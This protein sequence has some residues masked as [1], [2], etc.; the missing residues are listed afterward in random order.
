[1]TNMCMRVVN[2]TFFNYSCI[3]SKSNLNMFLLLKDLPGYMFLSEY[4]VRLC[5]V[6]LYMVVKHVKTH[7]LL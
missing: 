1:M 6:S 2:N 7:Y 3:P 5:L 4:T